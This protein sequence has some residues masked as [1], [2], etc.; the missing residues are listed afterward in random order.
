MAAMLV[1]AVMANNNRRID[2][3]I[4]PCGIKTKVAPSV[5]TRLPA[6]DSA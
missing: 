5:P 2:L 4:E 3:E 6:V 1:T